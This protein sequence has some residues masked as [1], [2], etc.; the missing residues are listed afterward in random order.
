M[1]AKGIPVAF[2]RLTED[3]VPRAPLLTRTDPPDPMLM[4]R[5]FETPLP[6]PEIPDDIG[7]AGI[8]VV[9]RDRGVSAPDEPFGEAKTRFAGWVTLDNVR[10]PDV[11]T[12]APVV[13]H[14]GAVNPTLV[15]A[16][17]QFG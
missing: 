4:P 11:V 3:G 8:S 14:E 1:P 12:G 13:S 10:F 6:R 17:D 15:T 5:A 9:V 2:A 16:V 7:I